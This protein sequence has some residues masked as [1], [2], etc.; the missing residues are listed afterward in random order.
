MTSMGH[1]T[2]T[3]NVDKKFTTCVML[4]AFIKEYQNLNSD[5]RRTNGLDSW[6][7]LSGIDGSLELSSSG[8]AIVDKT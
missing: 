1:K 8:S 5:S 6:N 7:H 3:S 2:G 4:N